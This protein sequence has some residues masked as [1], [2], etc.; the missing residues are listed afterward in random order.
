MSKRQIVR[1]TDATESVEPDDGAM[2]AFNS[3]HRRPTDEQRAFF[4]ALVGMRTRYASRGTEDTKTAIGLRHAI[5]AANAAMAGQPSTPLRLL[6]SA[7]N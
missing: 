1:V 4:E 5:V 2:S 3:H 6:G 7:Q